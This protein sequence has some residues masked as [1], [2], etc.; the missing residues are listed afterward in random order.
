MEKIKVYCPT[1]DK[2]V[3]IKVGMTEEINTEKNE[4]GHPKCPKYPTGCVI[5]CDLT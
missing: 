1:L 4:L 2:V 5:G 3:E